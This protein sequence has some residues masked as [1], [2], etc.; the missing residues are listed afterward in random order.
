MSFSYMSP[1]RGAHAYPSG[2]SLGL[3]A[4]PCPTTPRRD[5]QPRRRFTSFS[6]CWYCCLPS[7]WCDQ[8]VAPTSS[9]PI[10]VPDGL[11][12]GRAVPG[13]SLSASYVAISPAAHSTQTRYSI[14]YSPVLRLR[15]TTLWPWAGAEGRLC[16][17]SSEEKGFSYS[18]HHQSP[19]ADTNGSL[20]QQRNIIRVTTPPLGGVMAAG[21]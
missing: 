12:R 10:A 7:P 15:T 1:R 14:A 11:H 8:P 17:S 5:G 4:L 6:A 21:R 20:L 13:P 16:R 2:G 3:I 18:T 9:L 19:L